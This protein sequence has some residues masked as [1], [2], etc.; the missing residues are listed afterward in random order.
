MDASTA[1]RL[2]ERLDTFKKAH[3]WDSHTWVG[4]HIRRRDHATQPFFQDHWKK[5]NVSLD[6]KIDKHIEGNFK[7]LPYPYWWRVRCNCC[8]VCWFCFY[9]HCAGFWSLNNQAAQLYV[10]SFAQDMKTTENGMLVFHQST[11]HRLCS[12]TPHHHRSWIAGWTR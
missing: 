6:V 9:Q 8:G 2:Q 7:E 1:L 12:H 11:H 10:D 4:V 3:N 5:H